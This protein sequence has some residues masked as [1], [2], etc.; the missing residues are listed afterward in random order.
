MLI[1]MGQRKLSISEIMN[2]HSKKVSIRQTTS[3][4]SLNKVLFLLVKKCVQLVSVVV[5]QDA[6]GVG[7]PLTSVA[8]LSLKPSNMCVNHCRIIYSHV[9]IK[10]C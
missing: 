4:Q 5:V 9:C 10:N 3:F 2:V 8:I 1:F 7:V 6:K